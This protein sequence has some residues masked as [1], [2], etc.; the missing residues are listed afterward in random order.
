HQ[1]RPSKR[2]PS[3]RRKKTPNFF[4][5]LPQQYL[6]WSAAGV[7]LLGLL[8]FLLIRTLGGSDRGREAPPA[9]APAVHVLR[10]ER[11]AQGQAGT[12]ATLG[13]AMA[14][15][16]NQD[17]IKVFD[18]VIEEQLVFAD[19]RLARDVTIESGL[20]GKRFVWRAP[21]QLSDGEPL[22]KVNNLEGLHLRGF[23][24]DGQGRVKD[25]VTLSGAC[26]GLT[27]EEGMLQGFTGHG[28]ALVNCEGRSDKEVRL[29]RLQILRSTPREVGI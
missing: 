12:F 19:P 25:L 16:R 7:A 26:P 27:L 4:A 8:I 10:V 14:R 22:L 2:S 9:T 11:S 20:E 18:E 5:S 1:S 15:A 23:I 13:D 24:M 28:I 29:S 6:W 21:S 3:P 17:R